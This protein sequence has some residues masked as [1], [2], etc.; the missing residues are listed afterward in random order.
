MTVVCP[1][2]TFKSNQNDWGLI[3]YYSYNTMAESTFHQNFDNENVINN[4]DS[5]P[6]IEANSD[7]DVLQNETFLDMPDFSNEFLDMSDLINDAEQSCSEYVPVAPKPYVIPSTGKGTY[8]KNINKT[9]SKE[10]MNNTQMCSLSPLHGQGAHTKNISRCLSDSN[11]D[12]EDHQKLNIEIIPP[13]MEVALVFPKEDNEIKEVNN[14]SDEMEESLFENTDLDINAE[15]DKVM[16]DLAASYGL[17]EGGKSKKFYRKS[18]IAISKKEKDSLL[19][20]SD[21]SI[22]KARREQMVKIC[23][24][25][26]NC[27]K[28]YELL[29]IR[30][31]NFLIKPF[32]FFTENL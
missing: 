16:K 8:S 11:N 24:R 21:K 4:L 31:Q 20:L 25:N 18:L 3:I 10:K 32:K 12:T 7:F 6:L 17:N 14:E 30:I 15:F 5:P 13:P 22:C 1:E 2:G 29:T 23:E 28:M 19:H 26:L 9:M 27:I